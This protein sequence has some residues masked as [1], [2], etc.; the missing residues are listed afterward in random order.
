MKFIGL[1]VTWLE[2]RRILECDCGHCQ[3]DVSDLHVLEVKCMG[4]GKAGIEH[5]TRSAEF[6]FLKYN[7]VDKDDLK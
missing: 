7:G 2:K 5:D 6:D 4:C 1:Q 3:I